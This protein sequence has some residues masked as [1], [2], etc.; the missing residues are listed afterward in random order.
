[1]SSG[2]DSA[3]APAI[4][5]LIA[6][7]STVAAPLRGGISAMTSSGKRPAAATTRAHPLFRRRDQRQAVAPTR[8]GR[9][10]QELDRVVV[11]VDA[12][13]HEPV[14]RATFRTTIFPAHIAHAVTP[15]HQGLR[16]I[17]ASGRVQSRALPLR[18]AFRAGTA[19]T[20]TRRPGRP[21]LAAMVCAEHFELC[22][23][24][25]DRRL[26]PLGHDR[27]VVHRPGG[28]AASIAE[29]DER[30]VDIGREH[31]ELRE[32]VGAV[33][34][35]AVPCFPLHDA[36]AGV[37]QARLPFVERPQPRAP[38]LV[39]AQPDGLAGERPASGPG[40]GR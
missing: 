21:A 8:V 37:T 40:S 3:G 6:S 9:E 13:T 30:R 11:D 14:N 10:L 20:C 4:T 1:M 15:L 31:T 12:F 18:A 39:V 19:S 25:G 27:S 38:R 33:D 7:F 36:R 29:A 16:V 24:D 34:A 26:A 28:A 35:D 17:G 2:I 5:A 23:H 32:R 22:R